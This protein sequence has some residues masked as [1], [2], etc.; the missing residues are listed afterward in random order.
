VRIARAGTEARPTGLAGGD[1]GPTGMA[2]P[3]AIWWL[4]SADGATDD[5]ARRVWEGLFGPPQPWVLVS[6]LVD[7]P[8]DL[9]DPRLQALTGDLRAAVASSL[10]QP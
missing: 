10:E 2:G 3:T 7:G 8:A 4:Q 5:H 9:S 1:A 6:V